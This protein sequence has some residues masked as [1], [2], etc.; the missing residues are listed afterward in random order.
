MTFFPEEK[1][2]PW[3]DSTEFDAYGFPLGEPVTSVEKTM[4]VG[5]AHCRRPEDEKQYDTEKVEREAS[6]LCGYCEALS[7]AHKLNW[8][9][10]RVTLRAH[11]LKAP[12]D[13]ISFHAWTGMSPFEHIGTL[14]NKFLAARG[15]IGKMHSFWN[16][17]LGLPFVRHAASVSETDIDVVIKRSPQYMLRTL[18]RKPVLLT[19]NA[20]VQQVLNW[21][22]IN[23]WGLI[24]EHPDVPIW[25][26]MIDYGS[27]VSW[28][29]LEEI[30]GITPDKDGKYNE[31]IWPETGERFRVHAGLIDS[32]FQAQSEKRVYDFCIRN[33]NVFS[34]SK[35]G[36]WQHM[37]GMTVRT[38]PVADEKLD[39]FWYS[40]STFKQEL[41]YGCIKEGKGHYWLPY[42]VGRDF[43][44]QMSSEHTEERKQPDGTMKLEWVVSGAA[45]NHLSDTQKMNL[46]LG[47]IIEPK[48]LE[49]REEILAARK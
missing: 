32:G 26:A 22:S 44:E 45:G 47:T 17:E 39:L 33:A 9:M 23:A 5:F 31:Y 24:E 27:V 14:A 11:N 35:G 48:L 2:V 19:M 36:G 13:H 46:A 25:N 41:L 30:A 43:R 1:E 10:R 8:M 7:P 15:N 12:D 20:D 6:Y 18:P 4:S 16:D 42:D 3:D 29:Q 37:R 34:P 21:W 28:D 40:D 38:S 49:M